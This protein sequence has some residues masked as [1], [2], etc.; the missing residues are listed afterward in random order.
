MC[1]RDSNAPVPGLSAA[2]R[3]A[4]DDDAPDEPLTPGASVFWNSQPVAVVLTT[5]IIAGSS[6]LAIL[7]L[8]RS[9]LQSTDGTAVVVGSLQIPGTADLRQIIGM[10]QVDAGVAVQLDPVPVMIDLRQ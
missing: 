9:S 10:V 3:G 8:W 1:I 5:P 4:L 6:D 7:R 2:I